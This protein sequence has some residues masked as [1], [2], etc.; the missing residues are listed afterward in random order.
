MPSQSQPAL[1]RDDRRFDEEDI[2]A[3]RRPGQPRGYTHFILAKENVRAKAGRLEQLFQLAGIHAEG[4]GFAFAHLP[5]DLA[6]DGA[7][8]ALQVAHASLAGID[9]KS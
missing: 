5:R 4:A 7:D 1:A 2:P 8:P 9:R 3:G 6:T